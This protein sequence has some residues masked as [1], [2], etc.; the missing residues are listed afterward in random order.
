MT[1][2]SLPSKVLDRKIKKFATIVWL[3]CIL[4]ILWRQVPP[5]PLSGSTMAYAILCR[6]TGLEKSRVRALYG[7]A[8]TYSGVV[9]STRGT[10][11]NCT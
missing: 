11:G 9:Y 1:A 3:K 6:A 5:L 8:G 10:G 2:V 4:G 7:I